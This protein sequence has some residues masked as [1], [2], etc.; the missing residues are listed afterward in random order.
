VKSSILF[1]FHGAVK[2]YFGYHP[3]HPYGIQKLIINETGSQLSIVHCLSGK[4]RQLHINNTWSHIAHENT[5]CGNSLQAFQ[6][7]VI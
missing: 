5:L 4:K 2:K 6:Q 1:N 7:S 3:N